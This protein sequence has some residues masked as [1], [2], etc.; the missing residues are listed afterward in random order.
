MAGRKRFSDLEMT[1]WEEAA[2]TKRPSPIEYPN[3]DEI[4][5]TTGLALHALPD[6][7]AARFRQADG[8][9]VTLNLN[10]IVAFSLAR[11]ITAGGVAAGW[12]NTNGQPCNPIDTD[13]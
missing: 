2:E 12:L 9:E 8:S 13:E 3:A 11:T 4:P 6:G 5:R 7:I 1:Q 10:P